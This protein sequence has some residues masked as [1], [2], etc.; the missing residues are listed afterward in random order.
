ME[1][2]RRHSRGLARLSDCEI[3]GPEQRR[4]RSRPSIRPARASCAAREGSSSSL[5]SSP[6]SSTGRL[7]G[8]WAGHVGA[9]AGCL[10]NGNEDPLDALDPLEPLDPNRVHVE[11]AISSPLPGKGKDLW[12]SMGASL[13][14]GGR[15]ATSPLSDEEDDS[16][17][18]LGSRLACS[19][20]PRLLAG[21]GG[22]AVAAVEA[23]ESSPLRK[24]PDMLWPL[25]GD[26][27]PPS[28]ETCLLAA[29]CASPS[30]DRKPSRPT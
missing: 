26:Q 21:S 28:T 7:A 17:P 24:L 27:L 15:S 30:G 14:S 11:A 4:P 12:K 16:G 18:G 13:A 22:S 2:P 19:L 3:R 10:S 9:S 20:L 29:S 25:Q 5:K 23:S 6:S 1:E 8:G